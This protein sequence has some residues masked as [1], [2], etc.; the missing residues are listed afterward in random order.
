MIHKASAIPIRPF[1]VSDEMVSSSGPLVVY[2]TAYDRKAFS[3]ADLFSWFS[4]TT[5]GCDGL[6]G[7]RRQLCVCGQRHTDFHR[8]TVRLTSASSS[9]GAGVLRQTMANRRTMSAGR[10]AERS[11]NSRAWREG[12][13]HRSRQ[14]GRS[15]TEIELAIWTANNSGGKRPY[16]RCRKMEKYCRL[17]RNPGKLPG[18]L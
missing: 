13:S 17:W 15:E 4:A 6:G 2:A 9:S 10:C 8:T 7:A 18:V 3:S 16:G 5:P 12:V 14:G 1:L 11:W